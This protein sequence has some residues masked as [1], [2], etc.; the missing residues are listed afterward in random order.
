MGVVAVLVP[1]FRRLREWAYAGL[2]YDLMGATYSH[3]SVGDPLSTWIIPVVGL[4][5]V[6]G[7]YLL[8]RQL[9]ETVWA[10]L[11]VSRH[12]TAVAHGASA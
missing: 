3:L 10:D 11:S 1:S 4:T 5:L 9:S 2:V 6:V 7:S 12:G 8:Y